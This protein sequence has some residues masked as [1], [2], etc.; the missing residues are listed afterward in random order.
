V[1]S[2]ALGWV[3]T[4]RTGSA[5]IGNHFTHERRPLHFAQPNP[6]EYQPLRELETMDGRA[7][8]V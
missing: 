7:R 6:Y 5:G 2:R 4:R 3:V 1:S 8:H